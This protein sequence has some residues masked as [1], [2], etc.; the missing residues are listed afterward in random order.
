MWKPNICL[1]QAIVVP[2]SLIT[3][4]TTVSIII[5][6]TVAT[7]VDWFLDYPPYNLGSKTRRRVLDLSPSSPYPPIYCRLYVAAAAAMSA[8]APLYPPPFR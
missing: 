4:K 3:P 7:S 8:A 6:G 1:L 2:L 5:A